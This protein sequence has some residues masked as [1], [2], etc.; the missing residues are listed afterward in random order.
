MGAQLYSER[1]HT[2]RPHKFLFY[3]S[4]LFSCSSI[5]CYNSHAQRSLLLCY[6]VYNTLDR[7]PCKPRSWFYRHNLAVHFLLRHNR[8]D[9]KILFPVSL[10]KS[11]KKINFQTSSLTSL[12]FT[13]F[14]AIKRFITQCINSV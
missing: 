7:L 8:L 9:R 10:R 1:S 5:L 3:H 4:D 12:L 13:S 2:L 11:K 14:K 6:L